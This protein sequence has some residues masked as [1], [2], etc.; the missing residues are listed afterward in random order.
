MSDY[1][2]GELVTTGEYLCWH[3]AACVWDDTMHS[4]AD[5][6]QSDKAEVVLATDECVAGQWG[7]SC[8]LIH[9]KTKKEKKFQQCDFLWVL[10]QRFS[11]NDWLEQYLK[12]P[13]NTTFQPNIKCSLV[14]LTAA[15]NNKQ[16]VHAIVPC[17]VNCWIKVIQHYASSF[18]DACCLYLKVFHT[19]LASPG[20]E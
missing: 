3:G 19:L 13:Q 6:A 7:S 15:L 8:N 10:K 5:M 12:Y 1:L 17:D 14:L 20:D 2:Q 18:C 4:L 16:I 11:P 9:P